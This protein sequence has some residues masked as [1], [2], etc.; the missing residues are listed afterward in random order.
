MAAGSSV[1]VFDPDVA[2]LFPTAAAAN[3]ALRLLARLV[4]DQAQTP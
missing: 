4:R 1:V 2:R 3:E